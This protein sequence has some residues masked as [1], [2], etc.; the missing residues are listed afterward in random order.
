MRR[1]AVLLG[2]ALGLTGCSGGAQFAP[3]SGR[4]TLDGRPLAYAAV[5]FLP[6]AP[7][8][9]FE[10]PGPGSLAVT[11]EQGDYTLIIAGRGTPGAVVGDHRVQISTRTAVPPGATDTSA[12]QR[13]LVP[14][15]YNNQTTL[16]FVVQLGGTAEA[17]FD[18]RTR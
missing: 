9:K 2:C 16:R 4:V 8:G 7:T 1:T 10:A 14:P 6:M 18:L 15:K 12:P 3:V 11:D 5:Y 13:E 17:N